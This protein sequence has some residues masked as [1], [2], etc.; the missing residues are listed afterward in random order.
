MFS[1][2]I[3]SDRLA[4]TPCRR[5][6]LPQ[7]PE[8]ARPEL[9]AEE[10]ERLATELGA[11]HGPMLWLGAVAG[12]RFAECAGI[13]VDRLDLLEG[14]VTIDRQLLRDG[15]LSDPKTGAGHRTV[16]IPRWLAEEL[17]GVLHRR[18]LTAADGDAFVFASSTGAPLHYPNWRRPNWRR[19]VWVPAC[20]WAGLPGVVFHDHRSLAATVLVATGTDVKTAQRR[21]GHSSAKVT[22]DVYARATA[23]AADLVGDY[24]RPSCAISGPVR[25]R[26]ARR[27]PGA[28]RVGPKNGPDLHFHWWR[29]ADSIRTA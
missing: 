14:T 12:L 17:A 29:R 20:G 28:L 11:D 19:R 26:S 18:G 10:L 8:K 16:A 21:L 22:L 2:A 4:H 6:R 3:D 13:T 27:S 1:Y 7:V 9:S 24:L 23:A 5:I 15:T 25:A